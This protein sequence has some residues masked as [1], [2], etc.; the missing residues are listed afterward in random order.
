MIVYDRRSWLD[1]LFAWHGSTLPN[2]MPRL[3]LVGGVAVGVHQLNASGLV[4]L[5]LPMTFHT[6]LGVGLSL[7]VAFRT[8][9]AYDRFWEGRKCWGAIVNRSRN[10]V[11]QS[12]HAVEDPAF[13]RRVGVLVRA[14]VHGT[15]RNLWNEEGVPELARLL[16][17]GEAARLEAAPGPAQRALA[18]LG[19][20]FSRARRE[21]KISAEDQRRLEEDVTVLMDQ[22]G[23]CQRIKRTPIPFA[24]VLLLRRLL[25]IYCLSLPCALL[26]QKDWRDVLITLMVSFGLLGIEQIGV[27]IEDPFE[28]TLNDLDLEA[29]CGTIER[30]VVGMVGGG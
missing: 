21:G 16:P 13:A 22:L 1:H 29:I 18:E 4:K 11:R 3:A 30:D 2:L 20:E 9:T 6:L 15:K 23:A 19:G 27:E 28:H 17:A 14:F 8:N 10:L 5:A 7:L 25:L 12:L 26:D 24:Y